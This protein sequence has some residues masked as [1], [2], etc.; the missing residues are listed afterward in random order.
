[1]RESTIE[2]K[3]VRAVKKLG[4]E[5]KKMVWPQDDGAPDRLVMMPGGR[6]WFV[7]TKA[8]NGKVEPLQKLAHDDLRRLGFQVRVLWTA[9]QVARFIQEEVLSA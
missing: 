6:L 8:P 2:N 9:E 1:M 3:L 5:C 7:E 4:G